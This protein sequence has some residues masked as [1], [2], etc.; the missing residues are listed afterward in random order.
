MASAVTIYD[1][2]G[3]RSDPKLELSDVVTALKD[4]L[5]LRRLLWPVHLSQSRQMIQ[6]SLA[7]VTVWVGEKPSPRFHG[8]QITSFIP[9]QEVKIIDEDSAPRGFAFHLAHCLPPAPRRMMDSQ[10][11]LE[12]PRGAFNYS[13]GWV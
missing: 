6:P 7:G 9:G 8:D 3:T 4:S 1:N 10:P 5:F 11:G 12:V 13:S 2:W